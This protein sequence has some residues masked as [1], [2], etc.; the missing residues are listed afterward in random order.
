MIGSFTDRPIP[1]PILQ[2]V[3]RNI[4]AFSDSLRVPE[5]GSKS[6]ESI[7]ARNDAAEI[8]ARL[9]IGLNRTNEEVSKLLT[10]ESV[11]G[12]KM[13]QLKKLSLQYPEI[14]NA[15]IVRR[16]AYVS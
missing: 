1:E 11:R 2:V 12:M 4:E 5:I 6:V 7:E 14:V 3:A 9:L 15:E 10:T 13:H 8:L 16:R